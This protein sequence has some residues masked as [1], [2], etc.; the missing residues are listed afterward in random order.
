MYEEEQTIKSVRSARDF[1]TNTRLWERTF[2][3]IASRR[4]LYTLFKPCDQQT[5]SAPPQMR[6]IKRTQLSLPHRLEAEVLSGQYTSTGKV[7]RLPPRPYGVYLHAIS[8]IETR[9]R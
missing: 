2:I 8:K 6:D 5:K 4:G 3:A 7:N 9:R 1:C